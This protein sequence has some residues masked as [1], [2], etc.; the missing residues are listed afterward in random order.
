MLRPVMIIALALTMVSCRPKEAQEVPALL[1]N[2]EPATLQ[3][4][5]N[6]VSNATGGGKVTLAADVLTRSSLL[7]IERS[8]STGRDLGRPYHFQLVIT[9][10]ECK[11]LDR[12]TGKH[13]PLVQAECIEEE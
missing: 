7:V 2:P 1:T 4:I 13:W 12:Q 8:M 11:L 6:A 10:G 9:A 5:E 3:E